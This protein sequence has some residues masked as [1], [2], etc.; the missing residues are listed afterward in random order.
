MKKIWILAA[1][2]AVASCT[3]K[4][5]VDYAVVTG[6][7]TNP[8]P[9][10]LSINSFDRTVKEVIDVS[11]D[12]TFN[13]T[14]TLKRGTY[15]L[16]DGKNRAEVY[17]GPGDVMNI[18]F[19]GEDFASTLAFTGEAAGPS[20]YLVKKA[21]KQKEIRGEEN[22][23]LLEEAAYV[24]KQKDDEAAIKEVLTSSEN[25]SAE[26]VAY[27]EKG[28]TYGRYQSLLNYERAHAYYTKNEDFK[29]SE[30]FL[31]ET[32]SLDYTNEA[33][34]ENYTSYQSLVGSHYRQEAK[35]IAESEDIEEDVAFLKAIATS[36]SQVIKNKLAF[37]S[38]QYGITYTNDLEGFYA[39]YKA[40]S[41]DEKNNIAIEDSYAKLMTVAPG[42]LSPVFEDYE[43]YKGGTSSLAD[44]KGKYVYVDVWA[45]WCGPCKAEIPSLKKVEK[46]Y[47]GKNI[48]FISISVDKATDHEKWM[49]M[50]AEEELGGVQLFAENDWNSKFVQ[51]YLIKGIPRFLLIDPEGKIVSSNAPR[52]SEDRL[53]ELFDE[54]NI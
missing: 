6:Q 38:A 16:Y 44:F 54:L 28:L 20:N 14:L 50:V 24:A 15:L 1:V 45:T 27:E 48:E 21:A 7:I 30:G 47:H 42:K 52:P 34:F 32:E 29:V 2:F 33:D 23:Y 19:D 12:G 41:T 26:Y 36:P 46:E 17:V 13:D 35:K 8:V 4:A 3:K 31:A 40:V 11:E 49:N 9:G 5:S 39:A 10:E 53:I 25:L 37:Q 43:N 22:P 51:D 18:S